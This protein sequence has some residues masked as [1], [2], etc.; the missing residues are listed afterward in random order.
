MCLLLL[1]QFTLHRE[2]TFLCVCVCVH[3]SGDCCYGVSSVSACSTRM[4]I[5]SCSLLL[6]TL[7]CAVAVDI[8]GGKL[9][10]VLTAVDLE[11]ACYAAWYLRAELSACV[12]TEQA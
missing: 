8:V 3:L 6:A 1:L 9:P 11:V 4:R 5:A 2:T 10:L 7:V 12:C